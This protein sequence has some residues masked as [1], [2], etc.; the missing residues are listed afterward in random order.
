M[1][2]ISYQ[3]K[4]SNQVNPFKD[5][6]ARNF[7]DSKLAAEF[8]PTKFYWDLFNDQHE[9]LIGTRGS[10]KTI[11][12]RMMQYSLLK[13]IN[14]PKA[15]QILDEKKYL[16][17]YVPTNIEFLRS[18]NPANIDPDKKIHFFQFG[19][20]CLL[21]QT[22]ITELK[23]IISDLDD[24]IIQRALIECKICK[25]IS[26]MWFGESHNSD[27]QNLDNFTDL[28]FRIDQLY[29]GFNFYDEENLDNI[30][31]VFLNS[32]GKPVQCI[33]KHIY[34]V[35]K[36]KNEPIWLICIDEAEFLDLPHQICINTLFRAYSQGI[37]IKMATL[38]FKHRTRETFIKNEFAEPNGNDFNYRNIE[39]D[40][41]SED[42]EQLTDS[43]C[44]NRISKI[45]TTKGKSITLS[46]FLGVVGHDALVDYYRKET[47]SLN[48]KRIEIEKEIINQFSSKRKES[49]L[50]KGI[51]SAANRKA[52]YDKFAPVFFVREM[53]KISKMGGR[54]PGFYA[55]ANLVRKLSEGNPR[56]FIQIMNQLFEKARIQ[57]LNEKQ[58]H[59][60]L[61]EFAKQNCNITER[62][63][64][65]GG[66]LSE[67]LSSISNFLFEH[68]H[69]E[70]LKDSGNNFKIHGKLLDDPNIM[71]A[72]MLGCAYS[73]IKIDEN[74]LLNGITPSTEYSLSNIYALKYWIPIR[75]SGNCII[76]N[77]SKKNT[78]VPQKVIENLTQIRIMF[79]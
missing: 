3:I 36:M 55:G 71:N 41:N 35:L 34:E 44:N 29:H 60:T 32:I 65:Y 9:I 56:I 28:S 27:N 66:T 1:R 46:N 74:S 19:F 10:G 7:S 68:T 45:L 31:P 13:K 14:D 70:E 53:Y 73:R 2:P 79:E 51:G 33:S 15:R 77:G 30:P 62:L 64:E 50:E 39:F 61:M 6:Q 43:L 47:D 25:I 22:L 52:V 54:V 26:T 42:Y 23:S 59:L 69:K 18:I 5:S 8:Y 67:L 38:P 37:V 63:P 49:A 75:K 4:G 24:N 48:K 16:S 11:L 21:A 12:L 17:L 40:P 72:I 78:S 58:Q 76:W 57:P 20:N